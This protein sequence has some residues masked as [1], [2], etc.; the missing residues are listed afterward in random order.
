MRTNLRLTSVVLFFIGAYLITPKIADTAAAVDS[1]TTQKVVV[2][3]VK[4]S[5]STGCSLSC[6][7]RVVHTIENCYNQD[8]ANLKL[9]TQVFKQVVCDADLDK[10]YEP[11][12]YGGPDSQH[13][14]GTR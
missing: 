11:P 3:G 13:G 2:N 1:D 10:N 14:S 8:L 4:H 6:P 12:N 7:Y 9:D 5:Q